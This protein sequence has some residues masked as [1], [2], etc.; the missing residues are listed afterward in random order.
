MSNPLLVVAFLCALVF[1]AEWLSENTPFRRVGAALIVI[2][3]GALAANLGCIPTASNAPQLYSSIFTYLAPLAI[4]YLL[5]DANL[6]NIKKAGRPMILLFLTGSV[7][8]IAGS[9]LGI[10]TIGL[11]SL[12]PH[13]ASIAGMFTG[14][15]I[16]G[17]VNFN[18]IALHYNLQ[19]QGD[20][21][22]GSVAVDNVVT[23]LWMICC[24]GLPTLLQN[25]RKR[26]QNREMPTQAAVEPP[27]VE[28]QALLNPMT[29]GILGAVGCT[30]VWISNTLS[31][32]LAE[33]GWNF[34]MIL[35][36]T[37]IGILLAQIRFFHELQGSRTIGMFCV[38]LFLAVVGAFCEFKSLFTIGFLSL[39]LLGFATILVGVHGLVTFLAAGLFYPDW[40]MAS[41]ASQSNIGGPAMA[42]ALAKSLRRNDLVLPGL[43]VGSLGNALGTYAGFWVASLIGG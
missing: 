11:E 24:L 36:V 4:L 29:L 32:H 31:E 6:R 33:W 40:D 2:V 35:V 34:P 21:F 19:E 43:L 25:L 1:C 7:G 39:K 8:T 9:L 15:Y 27:T 5:L 17:S 42:L 18:A 10:Y 41:V 13:A 16:G 22:A 38:Y 28:E 20:I 26:H 30:A 23:A 12:Q 37:S 3:L 14:T